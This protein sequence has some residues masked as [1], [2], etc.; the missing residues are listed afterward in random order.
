MLLQQLPKA[1]SYSLPQKQ[2]MK[3]NE[4]RTQ[5]SSKPPAA[6]ADEHPDPAS[7]HSMPQSQCDHTPDTASTSLLLSK[8]RIQD[9]HNVHLTERILLSH[10]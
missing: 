5:T 1:I 3:E 7:P 8:H 4:P 6:Q 2:N 10:I 9:P